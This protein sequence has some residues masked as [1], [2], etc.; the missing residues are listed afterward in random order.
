VV[1]ILLQYTGQLELPYSNDQSS[2]CGRSGAPQIAEVSLQSPEN[3]RDSCLHASSV[4]QKGRVRITESAICLMSIFLFCNS[5]PP[6]LQSSILQFA[7]GQ[8]RYA[9]TGLMPHTPPPPPSPNFRSCSNSRL[10]GCQIETNKFPKRVSP[11][12]LDNG[13][14]TT[15]TLISS[16][17]CH[18]VSVI[19]TICMD[20]H[21][22]DVCMPSKRKVFELY[23]AR[24]FVHQR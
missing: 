6:H 20:S 8:V 21:T 12:D 4:Q 7:T 19:P 11:N 15:L 1:P 9:C 16:L 24:F 17:T 3:I 5:P 2:K 13:V 10:P 14:D 22:T 18:G 23:Q